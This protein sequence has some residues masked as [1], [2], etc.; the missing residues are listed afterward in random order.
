MS[1]SV[2]LEKLKQHRN[3]L[4]LAEVAA[5]LHDMGRRAAGKS[6]NRLVQVAQEVNMQNHSMELRQRG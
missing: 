2:D 6:S 5:W 4:L 3:A 1:Q